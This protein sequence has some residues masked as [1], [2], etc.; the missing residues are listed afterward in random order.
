MLHI[1]SIL[2][3]IDFSFGSDHA[4]EVAH[5]LARDHHS[6]IVLFAAAV[7]SQSTMD[8]VLDH[9]RQ[10]GRFDRL[11][12]VALPA[13]LGVLRETWPPLLRERI[14]SEVAEDVMPLPEKQLQSR[15][16]DIVAAVREQSGRDPS[17]CGPN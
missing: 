9:D 6:K 1:R 16:S 10:S 7:L 13:F 5:S 8:V 14:A 15:L 12:V 17:Q 3:P 4:V 11:F 2:V